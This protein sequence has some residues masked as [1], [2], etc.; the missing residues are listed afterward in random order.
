MDH[1]TEWW[2]SYSDEIREKATHDT[3]LAVHNAYNRM[4]IVLSRLIESLVASGCSVEAAV[5][6]YL[7][8][9][10]EEMETKIEL[11]AASC[12]DNKAAHHSVLTLLSICDI[13]SNKVAHCILDALMYRGLRNRLNPTD[14]CNVQIRCIENPPLAHALLDLPADCGLDIDAASWCGKTALQECIDNPKA[15]VSLLKRIIQRSSEKTLNSSYVRAIDTSKKTPDIHYLRQLQMQEHGY[16]PVLRAIY[17][18]SGIWDDSRFHC[19]F[20]KLQTLLCAAEND[21]TGLDLLRVRTQ[22]GLTPIQYIQSRCKFI[23]EERCLIVVQEVQTHIDR[24][25]NYRRQFPV[26][27][28]HVM[29][30]SFQHIQDLLN[31]VISYVLR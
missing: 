16:F 6:R 23:N 7:F 8:D 27:V 25:L 26:I 9:T 10:S 13:L 15:T 17:M 11:I 5:N 31:I 29:A 21:G 4:N 2:K 28:K 19:Q 24:V 12:K 20:R 30:D 18:T 3:M 22:T 14:S 1:K